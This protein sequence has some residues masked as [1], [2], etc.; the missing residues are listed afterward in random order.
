MITIS[1]SP[2]PIRLLRKLGTVWST[3]PVVQ[4]GFRF[5]LVLACLVMGIVSSGRPDDTALTDAL[6][7][8]EAVIL[9]QY[10]IEFI[11]RVWSAGANA[12]YRGF[13]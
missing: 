13:R 1:N 8:C 10:S 7:K 5:G 6:F 4:I 12:K 3:G 2:L 9:G 11:V